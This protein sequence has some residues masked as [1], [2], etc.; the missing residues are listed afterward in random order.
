VD[1]VPWIDTFKVPPETDILVNAT[2]IGL[3]PQVDEKPNIDYDTLSKGMYV[4]DVIP[5]PAFTPFLREADKRGVKWQSGLQMLINQ[6]ALNITMWTG[7]QPNKEVMRR[8]LEK[9][10]Q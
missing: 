6:A 3:Y 10:L 8:A 5:N 9:A 4:Q 7:K 2:S 1:Y